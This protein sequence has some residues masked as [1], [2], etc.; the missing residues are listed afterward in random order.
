MGNY[1]LVALDMD[2]TLLNEEKLISEENRRAIKAATEA[3]V[4]VMLCTG[5]GVP[6]IMSYVD[7]LQLKSP[8]VA[9]NGSEVWKA[10]GELWKRVTMDSALVDRMRQIA[11]RHDVW[12]WAYSVEGVYNKNNW[13]VDAIDEVKWLKFGYHIDDTDV[14]ASVRGELASWGAL[15]ITN[16]HPCNIE[17]N[18]KGI[19]K[20]SGLREVC[21]LLGLEM[22]QVVGMGDSQNDLEMI[23]AAGLGVAMGNAQEEIKREA[24]LVTVTNEEDGVARVIWEQVLGR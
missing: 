9:V 10:P 8:I 11:L 16:S 20:A 6:N 18:P 12:Y 14:L 21:A 24:D 4:T 19:S 13:S 22:S 23:R 2:G 3:G 15:E 1:K 17:L 5:R 7:E